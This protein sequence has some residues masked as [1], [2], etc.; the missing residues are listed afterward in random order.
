[1]NAVIRVIHGD[2]L[3]QLPKRDE[4]FSLIYLDPPFFTGS[5]QR[6]VTRDGI[7]EYSYD[8]SWP[9]LT[10][11]LDYIKV[12]LEAAISVASSS[13]S[14]IYHCDW[15][16]SHHARR[17]LEELLG[18]E[19][20]RAEIIWTYRRWSNSKRGLMPAHQTLLWFSMGDDYVFNQTYEAYS[21][22][23]NVDQLLQMRTRDERNKSVYALDDA[24]SVV[25]NGVKKGVPL[26]DV[27]DFPYLN[28]KAKERVGYPT[29]KPV[30][31]LSRIVKTF[32]NI[33]DLVLDPFCGSGTTLVAAQMLGRAACG[34]DANKDAIEICRRRLEQ[35]VITQS[36]VLEVGRESYRREDDSW[37]SFLSGL[38][39]TPVHRNSAIDAVLKDGHLGLPVLLRVQRAGESIAELRAKMRAVVQKKQARVGFVVQTEPSSQSSLFNTALDSSVFVVNSASNEIRIILA[40]LDAESH[41]E[42]KRGASEE[43]CCS[44]ESK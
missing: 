30:A 15:R 9:S 22:T 40:G 28:P 14:I 33:E 42:M 16:T 21:P 25:P 31:L 44:A 5:V 1:M 35:P 4:A 17:L 36:R 18:P 29:Q 13:A 19:H 6:S 32:S 20:F 27:W 39:V 23:T 37:T 38:A 34:I 43:D 24:G 12:R 2:C 11:Y 8:D 3:T 10:S 41:S 26:S 7:S